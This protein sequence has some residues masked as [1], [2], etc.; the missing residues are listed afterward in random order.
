ML[1]I[2]NILFTIATLVTV[3]VSFGQ[4][5]SQSPYSS[6][7][8][9][10]RNYDGYAVFSSMGEASL[11]NI[12]SNIVNST[13]PASYA[14][15]SRNLPVFQ[16]GLNGKLSTFSTEANSTNQRHFGLNQFQMALPFKKNWGMAIG[17][18]PYSFTGYTITNYTIDTESDTTLQAVNEG[19]GGVRIANFGISYR[20]M[21]SRKIHT[22]ERLAPSVDT[23][24]NAPDTIKI[25]GYK[26]HKMSIGIS[27]NYLFG[28]SEQIRSTEFIPS[29]TTTYNARVINGLRL[30][31]LS[32]EFGVNYNYSFKSAKINRSLGI[33]ATFSPAAEVRAFQD[34]NSFSYIGSFY[35]GQAVQLKDTIEFVQDDQGIVLKPESF[36]VGLQYQFSPYNSSS[37]L[38][39]ALDLKMEKWSAFYTQFSDVQNLGGLKDRMS[40]GVG[41]ER[42]PTL[43]A[44]MDR[45]KF[46]SRLTYRLG[47]NYAQTELLVKNNLNEEVAL[48]NYGMSFG[49]SI[50]VRPGVSNT[51]LNFGGSLGNLGT[52]ENGLIQD[53]YLGMYVGISITPERSNRWFL[54]RKYN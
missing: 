5:G 3:N 26:S 52:A 40:I 11:A 6:F 12:D 2:R 42:A 46:F 10:E 54:K 32:T 45:D 17:I 35:R 38:R 43:G 1:N 27:G 50:P 44:L 20:P 13:N 18:K 15:I 51:N 4:K 28:T 29:T 19:T 21:N 22:I 24:S 47:F 49:L 8:L 7:G 48:N 39:L 30:S 34:I 23:L 36:G 37:S 41:F 31:G 16:I 33:G 14:Y 25:I 9:G 53:R